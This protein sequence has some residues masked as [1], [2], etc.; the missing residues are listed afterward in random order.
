VSGSRG[1]LVWADGRR[2]EC[3]AFGGIK[4]IRPAWTPDG[5]I[6]E[7][8]F[9][10]VSLEEDADGVDVWVYAEASR[11][12]VTARF[13]EAAERARVRT[14]EALGLRPLDPGVLAN[15]VHPGETPKEHERR[16]RIMRGEGE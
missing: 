7:I 13:R 11:K 16:A 5:R 1:V 3:K 15:G 8:T 12:D 14:M 2:E 6:E 4:V 10:Y 9:D